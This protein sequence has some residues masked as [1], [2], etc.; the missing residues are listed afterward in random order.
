MTVEELSEDL[1]VPLRFRNGME[2]LQCTLMW[3]VFWFI[4]MRAGLIPVCHNLMHLYETFI[5]Y[6]C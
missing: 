5:K 3:L 1:K 4:D 6:L 2:E